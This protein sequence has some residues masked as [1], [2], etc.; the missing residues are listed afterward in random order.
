LQLNTFQVEKEIRLADS[1]EANAISAVLYEAFREFEP[2]YTAEGFAATTPKSEQVLERFSEGPVWVALVDG[3]LVGTVSVVLK[4]KALY[5]RGMAVL[6]RT[7]GARVGKLLMEQVQQYAVEKGCKRL[8]LSTTPFLDRA[9]RLYEK[10]GFTRIPEGPHDLFG[11]P[12][13]T[14]EK[15]LE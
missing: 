6:P 3:E 9:I 1:G 8:F 13:F 12:L 5:V 7:R 14:M 10:F 11:T 2:L 15:T 4:R